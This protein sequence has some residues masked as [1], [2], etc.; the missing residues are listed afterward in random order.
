MDIEYLLFLQNL[1]EQAA[2]WVTAVLLQISELMVSMIPVL[3]AA[4]M[5]WC[6]DKRAGHLMVFC[7]AGAPAVNQLIKN[8]ACVY[9]PWIRD[10]RLHIAQAAAAS[11]TG[12]SFPSGHTTLAV[13]F[14][15][16]L[17]NYLKRFSRWWIVPC[18]VLTVL[19]AFSRN[20][21]G[22]HTP[23]DVLTALVVSFLFL[24]MAKAVLDWV[25]KGKN[26]DLVLIGVGVAFCIA[27]LAF[28][29]LKRYP[30]DVMEDGT[31]LVDPWDMMTDCYKAAGALLGFLLGFGMERRWIRFDERGTPAR[32]ILRFLFGAAVLMAV[33][34]LCK[35]TV[36]VVL[37]AHWGGLMEMLAL[38]LTA[39]ALYPALM[40]FVQ[41]RTPACT[42]KA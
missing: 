42:N 7:S 20:W 3:A 17:A 21:L 38:T 16:G 10:S 14:Y 25:E 22:A 37:D 32:R 11:A 41:R 26:R 5:Y 2:P 19:T 24:Q 29:T 12:Y 1:R 34:T 6:V 27:M 15:G 13:G 9:R 30:M 31:L 35:R 8:T 28:I 33:R 4:L 36:C 18:A 40:A 39:V 23:Q